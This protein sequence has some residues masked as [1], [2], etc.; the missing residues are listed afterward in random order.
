MRCH[1]LVLH[2]VPRPMN[3]SRTPRLNCVGALDLH[4]PL[5]APELSSD[6][7]LAAAISEDERILANL[8]HSVEYGSRS[9]VAV[10]AR[11]RVAPPIAYADRSP[12]QS[13]RSPR[14]SEARSG[15]RARRRLQSVDREA[16]QPDAARG[17]REQP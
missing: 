9:R 16:L 1:Y 17:P 13:D 8:P 15:R 14:R 5:A 6:E 2:I 7:A 12:W 4:E 3:V 10:S 11:T